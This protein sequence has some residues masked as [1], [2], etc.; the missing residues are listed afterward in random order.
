VGDPD[1]ERH[2]GECEEREPR[3]DDDHRDRGED[4][5]QR[6]LRDDHEP[7]AEE[8]AHGLQVDGRARHE[9]AGLLTVEEAELEPEQVVVDLVAQVVLDAERDL[10]RDEAPHD[11]QAEAHEARECDEEREQLQVAAVLGADRVDRGTRQCGDR[12][13]RAHRERGEHEREPDAALVRLEECE[14][15]QERG[16]RRS[17]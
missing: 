1:D 11:R 13:G 4:D 6:R 5:R 8:E 12:D 15:A 17:L 14:Q 2:G 3:I 16:H 7:V 10:S 9:L